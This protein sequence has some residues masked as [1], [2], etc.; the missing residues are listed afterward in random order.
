MNQDLLKIFYTDEHTRNAVKE[1]MVAQLELMAIDTVFKKE[2]ID[3][4]YEAR[5][6]VD[7]TF[8]RLAEL[9][10]QPKKQNIETSR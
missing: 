2:S 10:A 4:I 8:N 5:A 9:Y 7:K 3:G 1:F 6:L